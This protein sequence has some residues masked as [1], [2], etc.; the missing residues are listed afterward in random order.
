MYKAGDK[1]RVNIINMKDG[2]ERSHAFKP[3]D[4]LKVVH[5][6]GSTNK[7]SILNHPDLFLCTNGSIEQYMWNIEFDRIN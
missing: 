5:K 2:G 7:K 1:V 3:K 6:Q 4:I